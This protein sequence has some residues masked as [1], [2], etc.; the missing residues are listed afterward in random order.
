MSANATGADARRVP[1]QRPAART[2][3]PRG[4]PAV[5]WALA[6]TAAVAVLWPALGPGLVLSY[7]MVLTPDQPLVPRSVGIDAQLP[8]AVPVDAVVAVLDEVVPASLLQKLALL[9][10]LTCAGAGCGL[11]AGR[12]A[13]RSAT[14][15]E[16]AARV[17]AAT[18]A[19]VAVVNPFVAQRLVIGHWSLLIAY[20]CLPW[21]VRAI[22]RLR[23]GR[24]GALPVTVLLLAVASV[25]PTGGV[26]ATLTCAVT[27]AAAGPRRRVVGVLAVAAAV[28]NAPWWVP[29][30]LHPAAAPRGE[31]TGV[32]QFALRAESALG[33]WVSAAGLG[34]IWNADVVTPARAQVPVQL[35]SMAVLGLALLGLRGAGRRARAVGALLAGTGFVLALASS[36][37][38][39]GLPVVQAVVETVPGGGL[40]RD[41]HKWLA[42]VAP[43]LAVAAGVGAGRLAVGSPVGPGVR[44]SRLRGAR[45]AVTLVLGVLLVV[46]TVPDGFGGVGGRLQAARYPQDW[47]RAAAVLDG[48]PTGD[49]VLVLPFQPFRQFGWNGRRT[50]LDPAP[51]WFA[52]QVVTEDRLTVGTTTL[53]AD[54]AWADRVRPVLERDGDARAL[55]GTGVDWVLV[56]KGTPGTVPRGWA[57][58][59]ERVLDG[60]DLAL[61]RLRSDPGAQDPPLP[62]SGPVLLADGLA[63]LVVALCG[64]V[65]VLRRRWIPRS[66]A[67]LDVPF[68]HRDPSGPG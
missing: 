30:L 23:H 63:L 44:R 7:D 1:D 40:L 8:R 33:P 58:G 52:Q 37:P 25:T 15:G 17:A 66:R 10:A 5:A 16:T 2:R 18:A 29:G 68:G 12:V 62:P 31:A 65:L 24:P 27:L 34:G 38:V 9:G 42:L 57:E 61:Y 45:P 51:R 26:L 11:L 54:S 19:A 67:G 47:H 32:A 59:A 36:L 53:T 49:A 21:L 41:A 60:P 3:A 14:G 39:V 4:V 46:A 28:V 6:L 43:V 55:A 50:V 20:A 35:A 48:E 13:G 64:V 22:G 56:E